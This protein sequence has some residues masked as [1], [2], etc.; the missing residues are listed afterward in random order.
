MNAQITSLFVTFL[1][2]TGLMAIAPRSLAQ[3]SPVQAGQSAAKAPQGIVLGGSPEISQPCVGLFNSYECAKAIEAKQLEQRPPAIQRQGDN[4]TLTLAT[5][6]TLTW[7][8]SPQNLPPQALDQIKLYSYVRFLPEIGYHLLHVQ[9]YE[10]DE[11]LLVHEKTGQ[12]T[13]VPAV[14]VI[15][16]DRR[17]FAIA[18]VG[19][20]YGPNTIQIWQLTSDQPV[21]AWS[22]EPKTWAPV[23]PR[24]LN[25][26]RLVVETDPW[27]R[28]LQNATQTPAIPQQI[29]I[30]WQRDRWMAAGT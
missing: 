24:W 15:S 21:L 9:Y 19:Y 2:G 12:Q 18:S 29:E 20:A 1:W 10:G 22:I 6:K 11:F 28:P 13:L 17:H 4:L 7:T 27:P 26:T 14:P 30:E 25:A 16:P 5:G 3:S 23:K 8:N